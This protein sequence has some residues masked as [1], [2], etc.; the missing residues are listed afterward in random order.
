M[1]DGQTLSEWVD[2]TRDQDLDQ[3]LTYHSWVSVGHKCVCVTVPK[4]ACSRIK[5]TLHL[6]DKNP[7]PAHLGDVHDAGVRLGSF[8]REQIVEMLTSPD[9]F[10]FCFV[11]NTY[12]RLLS[13]Y[14]PQVGNTWNEQYKWLKDEIKKGLGYPL[15]DGTRESLVPF[16]DF[17]R[18]L[19]VAKGAVLHDGHFNS[20][21]G[22]LMPHLIPYD[23]IG[24]F[25]A[26][27]SDFE[28][29]LNRLNAPPEIL[30][31]VSE[32]KNAT[33]KVH[34]AIAYDREL[35][36]LAYDLYEADFTNFGYDR[37]SWM[38]EVG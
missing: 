5:L 20:Q 16:R 21:V 30:A 24:R 10:R 34:P 9:W 17:V 35:A 6:L 38:Y 7:E 19:R 12:D 36:G 13:A 26:F 33:G 15:V 32:V 11:R 1:T 22:I 37:D 4:V 18:Y 29:V 2:A 28:R 8:G 3:I 23:F 31:T 25:E 14:K 27:Q